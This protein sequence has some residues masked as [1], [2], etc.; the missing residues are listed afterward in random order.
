MEILCDHGGGMVQI[1][2]H[3]SNERYSATQDVYVYIKDLKN[4]ATELQE[5]PLCL[6]HQVTLEVG[7]KK[8]EYYDYLLLRALV[9]DSVGHSAIE[10]EMAD[11]L[12]PPRFTH[13][14]FY[15]SC[16]PAL[17]NELGHRIADW[18]KDLAEP[19]SIEWS[20]A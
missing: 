12:K 5:F 3:A 13:A 20:N 4:F 19:L 16:E 15:L 2:V 7:S 10:I 8:P 18:T 11:H 9:H 17:V 14:H 1:K 6:K